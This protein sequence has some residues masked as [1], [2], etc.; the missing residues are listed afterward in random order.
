MKYNIKKLQIN[1]FEVYEDNKLPGRSYFIP[2]TDKKALSA[3][4]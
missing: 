3:R 2:Y 1:N 4:Q